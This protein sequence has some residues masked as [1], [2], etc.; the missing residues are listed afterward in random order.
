MCALFPE[1]RL[2]YPH[3]ILLDLDLI[4]LSNFCLNTKSP[5]LMVWLIH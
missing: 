5:D 3:L 2:G 1:I 4:P